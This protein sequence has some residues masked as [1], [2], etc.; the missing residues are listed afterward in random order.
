MFP[1]GGGGKD[2][3]VA[4]LVHGP[5]DKAV[6]RHSFDMEFAAAVRQRYNCLFGVERVS[7]D[8][9][10]QVAVAADYDILDD[11]RIKERFFRG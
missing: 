8:E 9:V 7:L 6:F 4:A 2:F 11:F 3:G 10:G 1:Q 5:G